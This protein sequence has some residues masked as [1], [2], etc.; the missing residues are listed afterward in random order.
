MPDASHPTRAPLAGRDHPMQGPMLCSTAKPAGW[1]KRSISTLVV[2]SILNSLALPLVHAQTAQRNH[3]AQQDLR[4]SGAE[5]YAASLQNMGNILQAS[6]SSAATRNPA[7]YLPTVDSVQQQAEA[8]QAEWD[9]LRATWQAAGV[10]DSIIQRQRAHEETF[11]ARNHALL[12]RLQAVVKTDGRDAAAVQA[13]RKLVAASASPATHLPINLRNMPWQVE[14]VKK[15]LPATTQA[16]LQQKLA[17]TLA[18]K[19]Q[20]TASASTYGS[21][22]ATA[23]GTADLAATIDAQQTPEIKALA[24]SL[25]NNPHKIYQW[26][27]DNIHYFPSHGSVQGAQDTLDKKRGNAFDTNSLLIA[28]LRASGI[29]ARYV[30]GTVELPV[31]QVQ[32][33]V[34]GALTADAAQQVLSQGGVPNTVLT[35]SGQD[36]AFRLEH[37][38]VEALIQYQPGRG[39]RHVPG[40]STP[41][42]WVPLDA[43]YKQYTFQPGMDLQTAVPLDAQALLDAA[44]QGSQSNAQE[45][46]VRNLNTTALQSQL[47]AYQNQLKTYIDSQNGGKSTVGDVL[48]T[49]NASIDP[50]PYLAGTLPYVIKA[51]TQQFSEVPDSLR[52]QF[53]YQIY[54]DQRSAAWGDS[55]LLSWQTPTASLAGKKVTMAWVAAS[56]A[57]QAAIEALIP[58]PPPGQDLDPSQ[59]PKGLPGSIRLK[60]EIRVD[61]STVATGPAM[62][63]GREPVG[64]GAFTRYGSQGQDWDETQDQLIAGQQTALGVSIQGISLAQME[65][66]KTRMQATQQKLQQAQTAPQDQRATILAGMTG[67]NLT[68]DLLTATVWGYF[69][70]LQSH[71]AIASSQAQTFDL[72]ALSYGLFHAQVKPNKL[73]G[74]VTTGISFQ[75]LN[76][77]IGHLRHIRWVKDDNPGSAINNKPELTQNGKSAAQNRWIAYNKMRGQYASAM[78]HAVPEQYWVDKS[79]CRYVDENGQTQNFAKEDCTQGISAVKAIAIAQSQGQKI[80]TINQSNRDTALPKLALGG[81]AVAEIRNAIEAGKEVTFH[82]SPISAHGWTG[83]GY[84]ITD[85]E[86]GAGAYIIEGKGNGGNLLFDEGGLKVMRYFSIGAPPISVDPEILNTTY[87]VGVAAVYSAINTVSELWDCYQDVIKE[88]V[89]TIVVVLAVAAIAAALTAGTGLAAGVAAALVILNTNASAASGRPQCSPPTVRLQVQESAYCDNN[90]GKTLNT[91]KGEIL[92]GKPGVGVTVEQ[93]EI[94]MNNMLVRA[95]AEPWIPNKFLPTLADMGAST[96]NKLRRLPPYGYP[97]GGNIPGMSSQQMYKNTCFRIDVENIFGANFKE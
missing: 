64:A 85:P 90:G 44:S 39:A 46:W 76:M 72:P 7:A 25:D 73:Y 42:T 18:A 5:R 32:N 51:R 82:E 34:G 69:A 47:N 81:G 38:W 17:L 15:S 1:F 86:T 20:A 14:A 12:Q 57:D 92:Y 26:V 54:A 74:I 88:A 29:P 16:E 78:E 97:K 11:A 55:P 53:R 79:Q 37:V 41:D 93:A 10:D 36:F 13:L 80:Y 68:G 66:L 40:V 30:Y 87:S 33:W 95:A 96:I 23:P 21:Q 94:G 65:A 3:A 50:L 35:K 56:P 19:T 8:L 60:P 22:A 62:S 27:H 24:I 52:T 28:L 77:D 6:P 67:E 61:G 48:G 31:A 58:T 43:S 4:T 71:G 70:S 45:G 2:A 84:T 59:L 49:R 63:A 89:L 91:L 9:A 83:H 75:G